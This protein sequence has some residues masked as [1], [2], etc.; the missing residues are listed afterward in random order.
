MKVASILISPVLII[1]LLVSSCKKDEALPE[2]DYFV[3][4]YYNDSQPEISIT[5]IQLSGKVVVGQASAFDNG[6]DVIIS[7]EGVRLQDD[8]SNY[9]ITKFIIDEDK[10][11]GYMNQFEF[12]SN[13]SS[14]KTDIVTVL[15]LD[16]SSSLEHIAD[17]LKS[18][19]KDFASTVV[20]MSPNSQVAVV[21]FSSRSAI[22]PSGFYNSENIQGLLNLIDSFSDYQNKTA[23]FEATLAGIELLNSVN[24]DGEKSL[25][26]FT[27]GGDNDSNNPSIQKSTID[28]STVNRF[29]IG[30]K[31]ED[32]VNS[33]LEFISS[34][35]SQYVVADNES[36]LSDIFKKITRGVV[37]V[38]SLEYS[39]SNQKLNIDEKI[40][41]RVS[42]EEDAI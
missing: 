11:N 39:R 27:D 34:S 26:V 42:M 19:A 14:I 28:E 8:V 5:P 17:D 25:V 31:G 22:Y 2:S 30:L 18:Y 29:S 35:K 40:R 9:A 32:F 7:I 15:V 6:S 23:L 24:F 16:M 41:I 3:Y 20:N 33:D 36:D 21:F 12:G 10:G 13:S 1:L 4:E 38:Y 37:S